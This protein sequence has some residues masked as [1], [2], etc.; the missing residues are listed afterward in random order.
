VAELRHYR[1]FVEIARRGSFTAAS[2]TLHIT[3][4]ALSEQIM[5]LERQLGCKLFDR[6][7]HGARLTSHG[8]QLL[9]LA[10][11]LLRNATEIERTARSQLVS[12]RDAFR[13][14]VTMSPLL[15]WLPEALADL[16][17]RHHSVDVY[18]EDTPTPE[19][20]LRVTTGKVDLGIV[21][22]GS[23]TDLNFTG[24]GL[25]AEVLIE[26]DWVLLAPQGHRFCAER[27]A[28]LADLRGESLIT[29]PRNSSLRMVIDDLLEQAGVP[30]APVIET[31]WME[32]G[33]RFVS[34]GLGVCVAPR[35]VTLLQ[36]PGVQVIDLADRRTPQRTLTA[37]YRADSPRLQWT[38]R[39]LEMARENLDPLRAQAGW[40]E[41]L[42]D[43]IPYEC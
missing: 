31:G 18:L 5:D 38:E 43:S 6:G 8:E 35:A 29:F 11:Q 21:S 14:A 19:T 7:R 25:V 34:A 23:R 2:A 41:D 26:D 24:S 1:Y 3:Q 12:R 33:I 15:M 16:R 37:I 30:A 39:I 20:F 40:N 4:S 10:E 27:R 42:L 32:M 9:N 13:I 28:T 17:R 22:V 36:H